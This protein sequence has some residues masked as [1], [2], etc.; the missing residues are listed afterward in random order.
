MKLITLILLTLTFNSYAMT[1]IEIIP[2]NKKFAPMQFEEETLTKAIKRLKKICKKSQWLKVEKNETKSGHI[3]S[4][5]ETD[6]GTSETIYYYHPKNFTIKIT[7]MTD[8]LNQI[9]LDKQARKAEID[10]LKALKDTINA[11]NL[12]NWHKKLLKHIVK[13]LKND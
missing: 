5:T 1:R 4:E 2:S 13:E 8:E 3:F 9:K 10:E 12:P 7:D 6:L 11:S